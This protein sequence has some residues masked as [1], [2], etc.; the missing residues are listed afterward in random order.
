MS[1]IFQL[2]RYMYLDLMRPLLRSGICTCMAANFMWL[3]S[4]PSE[5]ASASASPMRAA[6]ALLTVFPLFA[7]PAVCEIARVMSF[8]VVHLLQPACAQPASQLPPSDAPARSSWWNAYGL[9]DAAA[10]RIP[11]VHLVQ[12]QLVLVQA[13]WVHEQPLLHL[14]LDAL[15]SAS[16]GCHG[17][18]SGVLRA[19]VC[20]VLPVQRGAACLF[21]P[22]RMGVI[23]STPCQ[24]LPVKRALPHFKLYLQDTNSCGLLTN[25]SGVTPLLVCVYLHSIMGQD[26]AMKVGARPAQLCPPPPQRPAA[27]LSGPS[28]TLLK[29]DLLSCAAHS[30]LT[31]LLHVPSLHTLR[32]SHSQQGGRVTATCPS[33]LPGCRWCCGLT[34]LATVC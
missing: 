25:M 34:P 19:C 14:V 21:S 31:C 11:K 13:L 22:C 3:A 8:A 5:G 23:A 18:I 32:T 7:L 12:R 4:G 9:T 6:Q 30:Y 17:P 33:P 2:S 26:R 29:P 20:Q 24:A 27:I 1:R 15:A 28:C 10:K 16:Q